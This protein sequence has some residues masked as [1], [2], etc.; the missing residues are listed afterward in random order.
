MAMESVAVAGLGSALGLLLA[1]QGM[2]L[3]RRL[4]PESVEPTRLKYKKFTR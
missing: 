3:I 4:G 1:T 2:A